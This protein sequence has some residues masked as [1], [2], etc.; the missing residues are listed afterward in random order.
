M[1]PD[2]FIP[3]IDFCVSHNIGIT[4]IQTF[5]EAGLIDIVFIEQQMFLLQ[6]TLP[7]LEKIVRLHRDLDINVAGIE[8][9]L[10]LLLKIEDMQ[11]DVLLLT[12]RLS[13]FE[14]AEYSLI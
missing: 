8:S 3:A 11:K 6:D 7:L 9:I 12:H 4:V 5:K 14:R 2:K 1:E 13:F 10:H